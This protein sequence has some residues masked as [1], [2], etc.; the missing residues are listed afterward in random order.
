LTFSYPR[1]DV[2]AGGAMFI[3]SLV[4]IVVVT[5]IL[6]LLATQARG[7]LTAWLG[8]IGTLGPALGFVNVYPF[9]FSYVADH[10]QYL[11]SISI[12]ALAAAALIEL[13]SHAA[14]GWR[15]ASVEAVLACALGIP[16]AFMTWT[17]SHEYA[18]ADGL[19]LATL[20]QNPDC[21]MCHVNLAQRLL[22]DDRGDM[23]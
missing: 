10:F 8:F 16:L 17:Q 19:F 21:G 2:P 3:G 15:T 14:S 20:R 9:R 12:I 6:A 13:A 4:L 22:R 5:A 1:W 7:P 23:Q 18:D 11:A